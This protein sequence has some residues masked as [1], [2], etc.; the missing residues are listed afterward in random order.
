MRIRIELMWSPAADS[1]S[2]ARHTLGF[3]AIVH[4][5]HGESAVPDNPESATHR[6]AFAT[7]SLAYPPHLSPK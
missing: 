5:P 1:V 3:A 4:P 7:G 6:Q 2:L